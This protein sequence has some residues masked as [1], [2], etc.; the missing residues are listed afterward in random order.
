MIGVS[1]GEAR[2]RERE[3]E[4]E[5]SKLYFTNFRFSQNLTTMKKYKASYTN[6]RTNVGVV[7]ARC[8]YTYSA[9]II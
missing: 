1:W 8:T 7:N 2:E 9:Y 5:N 3:G 4:R 6:V